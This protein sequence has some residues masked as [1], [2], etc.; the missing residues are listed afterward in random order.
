[1]GYTKQH[2]DQLPRIT[3]AMEDGLFGP[4]FI[5]IIPVGELIKPG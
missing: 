5:G 1:M 3:D 4:C 2:F